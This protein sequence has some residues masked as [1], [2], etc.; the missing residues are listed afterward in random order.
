MPK[1]TGEVA[2]GWGWLL[3]HFEKHLEGGAPVW[4]LRLVV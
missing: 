1:E 4:T 2:L 3:E